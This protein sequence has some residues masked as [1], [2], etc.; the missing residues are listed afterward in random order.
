M[1]D[2][3]EILVEGNAPAG[4]ILL[5]LDRCEGN[6]NQ[7]RGTKHHRLAEEIYDML[8]VNNQQFKAKCRDVP[9]VQWLRVCASKTGGPG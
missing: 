7:T 1:V 8:R 3:N 9:V 4:E 6:D 2:C 5:V